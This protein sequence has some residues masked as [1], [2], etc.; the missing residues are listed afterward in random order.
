MQNQSMA[1]GASRAPAGA[2]A[3]LQANLLA[4]PP[5]AII[6]LLH[7]GGSASL[8]RPATFGPSLRDSRRR[9]ETTE[10]APMNY[11]LLSAAGS[12]GKRVDLI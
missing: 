5:T 4:R 11:Y 3:S 12:V 10:P 7:L 8:H 6:P 9:A 1:C 2:H